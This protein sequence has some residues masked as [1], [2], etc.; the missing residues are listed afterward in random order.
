MAPRQQGMLGECGALD[1]NMSAR[2]PPSSTLPIWVIQGKLTSLCLDVF[3][4]CKDH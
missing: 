3:I 4:L 1:S 2:L